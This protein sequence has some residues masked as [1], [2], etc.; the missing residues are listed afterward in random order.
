MKLRKE[1]Q[2]LLCLR[3]YCV[4]V[5]PEPILLLE[6]TYPEIEIKIIIVRYNSKIHVH[7]RNENSWENIGNS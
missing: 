1:I 3:H 4:S 7:E 6:Q 5:I 2:G